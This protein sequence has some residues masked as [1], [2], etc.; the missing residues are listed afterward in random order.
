M[1]WLVHPYGFRIDGE[2]ECKSG[3]R[4]ERVQKP[5]SGYVGLDCG[6][7]AALMADLIG[8]GVRNIMGHAPVKG[9][10]DLTFGQSGTSMPISYNAAV[11][12]GDD[13][14]GVEQ[15]LIETRA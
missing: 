3:V 8:E 12:D 4:A 2:C 13:R 5:D 10:G 7:L 11:R 14:G 6:A 1:T 15:A 9:L